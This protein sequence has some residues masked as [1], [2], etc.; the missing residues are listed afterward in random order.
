MAVTRTVSVLFTDL[1]GSTALMAR[2]GHSESDELRTR[3]F[4]TLRRALAV[5]RGTEVKSLGDGLM[6]VFGSAA[7]GLAC[8]ITMQRL[9]TADT[10]Q[11]ERRIRMRVAISAGEVTEESGDYFGPPVVEASRLCAATEPGQILASDVVR[12]LVGWGGMH[13]LEPIAPLELKGI[14]GTVTACR[15]TWDSDDER[16]LRVALADDSALLRAGVASVLDSEGF[17]VVLQ[18]DNAVDLMARLEAANP[19]VVLLDVR[20][21]P[22]HTTEGLDAAARIRKATPTIGVIVLS[23]ELQARAAQRL[24][25]DGTDGIGYLLKDRVADVA[26]LVTAIRTV[27][28]G[29]SAIDPTVVAQLEP[30][31]PEPG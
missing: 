18:C 10:W 28:S 19:D 26:E 2:R 13:D 5:H 14:P 8:S 16:P 17:D 7:D 24:L 11:R 25:D 21:P 12:M 31:T 29:G 3:H 6:T 4:A 23:A 30:A 9:V 27:A 1:V 20:M 15:V 22:T